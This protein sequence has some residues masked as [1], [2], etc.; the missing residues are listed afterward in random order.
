LLGYASNY[1]K[2]LD[3]DGEVIRSEMTSGD[4]KNLVLTFEKHFGDYV[5]LIVPENL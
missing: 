2:Q 4:Y 3:L 5:D 1:A